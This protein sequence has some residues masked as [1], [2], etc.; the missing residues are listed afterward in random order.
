MKNWKAREVIK[1][2]P[3]LKVMTDLLLETLLKK[4][5]WEG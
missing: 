1:F 3:K 2:L 4:L 5:F